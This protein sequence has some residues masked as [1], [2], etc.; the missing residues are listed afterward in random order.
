MTEKR[1]K[2]NDVYQLRDIINHCKAIK[3][4]TCDD[5]EAELMDEMIHDYEVRIAEI[6][7]V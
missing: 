4:N 1:N 3:R 5:E 7:G 6:I 2:W